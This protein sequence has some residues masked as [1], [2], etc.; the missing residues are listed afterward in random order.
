[1]QLVI[2]DAIDLGIYNLKIYTDALN[3]LGLGE[4]GKNIINL[5]DADF[6]SDDTP[7]FQITCINADT[8]EFKVD[9]IR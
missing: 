9:K 6:A 1:M 2:H 7:I 8:L 4:F 5:N 3:K